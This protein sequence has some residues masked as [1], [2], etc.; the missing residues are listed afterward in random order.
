LARSGATYAIGIAAQRLST[1]VLLPV[2]TRVL[3]GEDV[4][5]VWMLAAVTAVATL[6]LAAGL[7]EAVIRFSRAQDRRDEP[8]AAL[9]PLLGWSAIVAAM[10]WLFRDSLS[11]ILLGTP[12]HGLLIGIAA[13]TVV[14]E[15]GSQIPLALLRA[16]GRAARHTAWSFTR[17]VVGTALSL[18]FLLGLEMGLLGVVLANMLASALLFAVAF[19]IVAPH[20]RRRLSG[21]TMKV[22]LRFGA[23]I[24]FAALLSLALDSAYVYIL[25]PTRGLEEL[26]QYGAVYRVAKLIHTLLSQPFSLAWLP[27]VWSVA[28]RPDEDRV[29]ARALTYTVLGISLAAMV[30][31]LFR[32]ELV[33][34]IA[35]PAYLSCVWAF[36]WI[37]AGVVFSLAAQVLTTALILENRTELLTATMAIAVVVNVALCLAW[38]PEHGYR[39]A[40]L[41]SFVSSALLPIVGGILAARVR[42]IPYEWARVLAVAAVASALTALGLLGERVHGAGG[43]ALRVAACAAAVPAFANPWFLRSSERAF[44]ARKLG[45]LAFRR[46]R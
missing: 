22:L 42:S 18:V 26:S 36:P 44:V 40:A 10:A 3:S 33:A 39:G 13:I 1:L 43:V 19:P 14:F 12:R 15:V 7:P 4:G 45:K 32:R 24:M 46:N 28:G 11:V 20:L 17:F 30:S 16:E 21:R 38:I 8:A 29:Y 37:A 5:T 6:V 35:S 25:R 34:L 31:I 23:P 2:Y 9:V 27:I 41:A